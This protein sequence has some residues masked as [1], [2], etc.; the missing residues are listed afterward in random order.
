LKFLDEVTL[1]QRPGHSAR[2]C[3]GMC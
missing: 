1:R 2:P 3:G